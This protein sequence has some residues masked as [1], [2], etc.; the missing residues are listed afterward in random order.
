MTRAPLAALA[1]LVA[2]GHAGCLEDSRALVVEGLPAGSC[3]GAADSAPRSGSLALRV[4][5][6]SGSLAA[7][8]LELEGT[9]VA[10]ASSPPFDLALDTRT[11]PDGT[12]RLVVRVTLADGAELL[13]RHDTCID[14]HGPSLLVTGPADG[15]IRHAPGPPL[16]FDVR[17]ED[18]AGGVT[19]DA[20]AA[21]PLAPSG[22]PVPCAPTGAGM[23]RCT[24]ALE[25]VASGAS[26]QGVEVLVRARDRWG[27][28]S[29]ERRRIL[30]RPRLRWNVPTHAPV[31]RTPARGAD[32]SL[33]MASTADFLVFEPD[34]TERCRFGLPRPDPTTPDPAGTGVALS[35]DGA[36][37]YFGTLRRFYAIS[38]AN[39]APRWSGLPE[40]DGTYQGSTPTVDPRDGTVFVGRY[41]FGGDRGE[42]LAIRPAD[43]KLL[44]RLPIADPGAPVAS[45]PVLDPDPFVRRIYVGSSDRNLYAVDLDGPRV[46]WTYLT[47]DAISAAPLVAGGRVLVGSHDGLLHAVARETGAPDAWRLR[48]RSRI[49]STPARAADGTIY[50]GSLD[51][52]VYA[53][54]VLAG[55][56]WTFGDGDMKLLDTA[57]VIAPDGTVLVVGARP[58]RVVALSPAGQELWAIAPAGSETP[59]EVAAS[60]VLGDGVVYVATRSGTLQALAVGP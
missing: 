14:N 59:G 52:N 38:T 19:V 45:S 7:V 26:T 36:T 27:R 55:L 9:A 46:A 29:L 1:A 33:A 21:T 18:A 35:R 48:T 54:D 53:A 2:L 6:T 50:V 56:R 24:L 20:A 4:R 3:G 15:A 30:V 10:R 17:A 12:L 43:G 58:T 31:E 16:T 32:G 22:V 25:A 39:C 57:P 51:G 60:P 28:A 8:A 13:S 44:W 40:L 41:G 23:H 49:Q 5:V 34:G 11:L 37:A 42:L 47:G